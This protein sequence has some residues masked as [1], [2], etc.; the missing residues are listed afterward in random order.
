MIF[1]DLKDGHKALVEHISL[2]YFYVS[3][4]TPALN[5]YLQRYCKIKNY[6]KDFANKL[7]L[8]LVYFE[9]LFIEL[10]EIYE[11]AQKI[12]LQEISFPKRKRKRKR[13]G[14]RIIINCREEESF[15][16]KNEK[17]HLFSDVNL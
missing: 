14:N 2:A 12:D 9:K 5:K 7:E 8:N 11:Y 1:E 16:Y 10:D 6:D 3:E 15:V 4:I 13:N 17:I